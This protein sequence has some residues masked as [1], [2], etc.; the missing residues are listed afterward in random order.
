MCKYR[1]PNELQV[2]FTEFL[3]EGSGKMHASSVARVEARDDE[4]TKYE[5]SECVLRASS[6]LPQKAR[7]ELVRGNL[8][9]RLIVA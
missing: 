4:P 7:R 6:S 1:R 3:S 9:T 8:S 2:I 5:M